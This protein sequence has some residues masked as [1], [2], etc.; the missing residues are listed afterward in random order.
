[1]YEFILL[2]YRMGRLTPAQVWRFV[3]KWITE[4]QAEQILAGE[5]EDHA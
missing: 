1:M 2:Q 3:P 4:E 5:E